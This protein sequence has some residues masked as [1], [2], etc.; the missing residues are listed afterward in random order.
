MM[1]SP[2][3]TTLSARLRMEVPSGTKVNVL[4]GTSALKSGDG[5]GGQR[6]FNIPSPVLQDQAMEYHVVFPVDVGKS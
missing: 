3:N 5:D 1:F 2:P 4:V 6:V